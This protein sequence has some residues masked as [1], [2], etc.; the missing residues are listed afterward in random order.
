ML[1]RS[2][3]DL[4]STPLNLYNWKLSK[5]KVCARCGKTKSLEQILAGCEKSLHQ[6]TRR[7]NQVLEVMASAVESQCQSKVPLKPGISL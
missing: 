5:S 6:Y 7:Y 4:L 2:V 1:L 3:Y